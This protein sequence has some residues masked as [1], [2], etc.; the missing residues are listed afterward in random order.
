MVDDERA[1][2]DDEIDQQEYLLRNHHFGLRSAETDLVPNE[3]ES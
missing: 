3:D 1:A 2:L